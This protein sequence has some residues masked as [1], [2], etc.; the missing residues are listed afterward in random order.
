MESTIALLDRARRGEEE[1]R[2]RLASRFFPS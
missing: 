2:E 1:A